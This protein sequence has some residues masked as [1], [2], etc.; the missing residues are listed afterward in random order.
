MFDDMWDIVGKLL[1]DA[2]LNED[3]HIALGTERYEVA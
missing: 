3:L 2:M 1:T